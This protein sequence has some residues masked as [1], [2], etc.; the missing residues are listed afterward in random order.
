M[1]I[2]AMPVC[3][4]FGARLLIQ[5]H[6]ELVFEVPQERTT[7]FLGTMKKVLEVPPVT[8]FAVPIIVEPKRGF[9]FGSLK[10]LN[11]DK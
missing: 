2:R 1:M 5:I 7:E 9:A 6:D 8:G 11:G 3:E 4:Q 10:K